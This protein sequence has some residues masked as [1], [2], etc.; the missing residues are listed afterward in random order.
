MTS[1]SS[2]RNRQRCVPLIAICLVLVCGVA[3][4]ARPPSGGGGGGGSS[5]NGGGQIYFAAASPSAP[6]YSYDMLLVMKDDGTEVTQQ[7]QKNKKR[8]GIIWPRSMET[9]QT[10]IV[11]M[12][13]LQARAFAPMAAQNLNEDSKQLPCEAASRAATPLG[14][15]SENF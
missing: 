6:S 11:C 8:T 15:W 14:S 13:S 7:K 12:T 3:V 10:R 9:R 2:V 1:S 5:S 4:S